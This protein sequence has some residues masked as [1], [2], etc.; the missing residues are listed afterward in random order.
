MG[1]VEPDSGNG[2]ITEALRWLSCVQEKISIQE[3]IQRWQQRHIHLDKIQRIRALLETGDLNVTLEQLLIV[4][5]L[6]AGVPH[7]Q[8]NPESILRRLILRNELRDPDPLIKSILSID[9]CPIV[10]LFAHH[11]N[12]EGTDTTVD[13]RSITFTRAKSKMVQDPLEVMM[14]ALATENGWGAEKMNV[15]RTTALTIT[16]DPIVIPR[17]EE[18]RSDALAQVTDPQITIPY[19]ELY[20]PEDF[21]QACYNLMLPPVGERDC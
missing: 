13:A 19:V 20:H 21:A 18:T 5:E 2:N 3:N 17:Q 12:Q 11:A 15:K 10:L 14:L 1:K 8:V 6:T 9:M 4:E 16:F 7:R